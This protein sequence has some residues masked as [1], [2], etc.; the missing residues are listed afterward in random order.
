MAQ[1]ETTRPEARTETTLVVEETSSLVGFQ[2]IAKAMDKAH[3][4]NNKATAEALGEDS[5]TPFMLTGVLTVGE[6]TAL[7]DESGMIEVAASFQRSST[8][9]IPLTAI[10]HELGGVNSPQARKV[11][12]TALEA[13]IMRAGGASADT[14]AAHYADNKVKWSADTER[15]NSFLKRLRAA[16]VR[17][18]SAAV[19]VILD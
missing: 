2:A 4:T 7:I 15:K 12:N 10:L 16:T 14:V 18:V 19:K 8:T 17:T 9:A 13:A 3:T 1:A 5:A 11:I 6:E